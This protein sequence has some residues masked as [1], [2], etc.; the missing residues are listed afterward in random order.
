M[1]CPTLG[2]L[3]P[4][5]ANQTGWPWTKE[6][7][8]L[9]ETMP[10]GS[11][12]PRI[13]IVTPAYN[14]GPL[15][16]ETIRSVLLQGYPDL[17]YIVIDGASTDE[18]VEIIRRYEPWLAY[19]VS[20]PDRGQAHAINK[21]FAK[22]TG[23]LMGWI[24]A[25][26]LLLPVAAKHL[27]RAFRQKPNAILLGDVINFYELHGG[28]SRL[29]CPRNVS[30]ETIVE[31][32][33]YKMVWHQP[34]LYVPRHLYEQVGRLD[35]SLQYTFDRDWLCRLLQAGSIYYVHQ[36]LAKFR[37][38]ETTKTVAEAPNWLPEEL[39]VSQ[40]YWDK[41]GGF[42]RKLAE[43]AFEL[44]VASFYLVLRNW[45][46]GKGIRHLLKSLRRHMR[47]VTLPEFLSSCLRALTPVG[48]LRLARSIAIYRDRFTMK[49]GKMS[50]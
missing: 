48:L 35:E 20:E 13:T 27:A 11:A 1:R 41:V 3:P 15:I 23:A 37:Y 43:A 10:D 5:P 29:I 7:P 30:F 12:W 42:D 40:R 32:W 17:E 44:H 45:N 36:P 6:S 38:H 39:A 8:R 16:E 21:G 47:V 4:P 18:S 31:P 50:T 9:P 2:E 33:R 14:A 46:R 49:F 22:C 26:D 25:D 24:N 28:F 34:G 19:W